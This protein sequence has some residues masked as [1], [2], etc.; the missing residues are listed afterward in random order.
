MKTLTG[1][2]NFFLFFFL[3]PQFASPQ[4]TLEDEQL[5]ERLEAIQ[6]RLLDAI[7]DKGERKVDFPNVQL[8]PGKFNM[9]GLRKNLDRSYTIKIDK[10]TISTLF[11]NFPDR[12]VQDAVLA[13][14]I[15]HEM[16]HF[17]SNEGDK[18]A[19]PCEEAPAKVQGWEKK[20]DIYGAFMAERAGYKIQEHILPFFKILYQEYAVDEDCNLPPDIRA[21]FVKQGEL[22]A[23]KL[24]QLYKSGQ[25]LMIAGYYAQA[26][27][28]FQLVQQKIQFKELYNNLGAVHL[29]GALNAQQRDY[30]YCY[31]VPIAIDFP[32]SRSATN[33]R[34]GFSLQQAIAFFKN[35]L[36]YDSKDI[37]LL[38]NL[39][40]A[41]LRLKRKSDTEKTLD[42]LLVASGQNAIGQV[43]HK[44]LKA[45]YDHWQT[46]QNELAIIAQLREV[47]YQSDIPEIYHF[48]AG[49]NIEYI[50]SG[51]KKSRPCI[52][53]VAHIYKGTRKKPGPVTRTLQLW[54]D[55]EAIVDQV[56]YA[57][58]QI[59]RGQLNDGSFYLRLSKNSP[60][61]I[62]ERIR[63]G[64]TLQKIRNELEPN[65]YK[66]RMIPSQGA[67]FVIID[68][69]GVI[70]R[71]D[72][73]DRVAEWVY[74]ESE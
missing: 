19:N 21:N 23:Q 39:S 72:Q 10:L 47:Q 31:P 63:T 27:Q 62:L 60:L 53:K 24:A 4:S 42:Q 17:Y 38:I 41:Y 20:A 1:L 55:D 36:Q 44:I 34:T 74:C 54:Q 49:C 33:E 69:L 46:P 70:Y 9:A 22:E 66:V 5:V 32:G 11:T 35:G 2:I 51:D 59:I 52:G 65:G 7:G 25:Y 56:Q 50:Q 6:D 37:T 16:S 48:I 57:E 30:T 28:I 18:G 43:S 40:N 8:R 68:A 58:G 64:S 12:Q 45:I 26:L 67:S 71:L 61:E 29:F 13:F 73:N 3:S 14:L 15:G